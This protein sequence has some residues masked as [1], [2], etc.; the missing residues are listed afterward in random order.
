MNIYIVVSEPLSVTIPVTDWGE[1]PSE[2]YAIVELVAA[3]TRGKAKWIAVQS[4]PNCEQSIEDM[5]RF[6]IRLI[7]KDVDEEPGI[8]SEKYPEFWAEWDGRSPL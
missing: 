1:G 2:E 7:R 3:E 6:S 4:D 5:P 8:V